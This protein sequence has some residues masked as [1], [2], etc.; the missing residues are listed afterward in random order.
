M[1]FNVSVE[2]LQFAH[3][4]AQQ[5]DTVTTLRRVLQTIYSNLRGLLRPE[6]PG[7]RDWDSDRGQHAAKVCAVLRRT[8][9][10]QLCR[11]CSREPGI[12]RTDFV[13]RP[14]KTWLK[15]FWLDSYKEREILKENDRSHPKENFVW[16]KRWQNFLKGCMET[17]WDGSHPEENYEWE[18]ERPLADYF[19]LVPPHTNSNNNSYLSKTWQ[20]RRR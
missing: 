1:L 13:Q 12:A 16:E 14:E 6:H 5:T 4:V 20:L 2:E 15:T 10:L 3:V 11:P 7:D 17:I 9:N 19:K 8:R 18:E